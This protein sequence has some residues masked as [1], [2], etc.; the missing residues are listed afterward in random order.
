M[1]YVFFFFF[2]TR[3][4]LVRVRVCYP[5][6]FRWDLK[7]RLGLEYNAACRVRRPAVM[8]LITGRMRGT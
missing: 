7:G 1:E 5:S 8:L 3:G 2:F 6:G 4:C